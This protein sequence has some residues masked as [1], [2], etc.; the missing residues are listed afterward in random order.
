MKRFSQLF[1][2]LL[3]GVFLV[4]IAFEP[5]PV[6]NAQQNI[7]LNLEVQWPK[8]PSFDNSLNDIA[9][10]G[11]TLSTLVLFIYNFLLWLSVILAFVAIIY[12]GFLYIIS[13]ANPGERK[14]AKDYIQR[15]A[16]G[17]VILFLA[18][19]ILS[20]INTDL[21]EVDTSI[22]EA[23]CA[24][25]VHEEGCRQAL[26]GFVEQGL[27][28]F[29]LSGKGLDYYPIPVTGDGDIQSR[30]RVAHATIVEDKLQ[31]YL[32][33][34]STR[35][36]FACVPDNPCPGGDGDG[37]CSEYVEDCK[38]YDITR[39]GIW[40][41][42]DIDRWRNLPLYYIVDVLC[43]QIV[44][45]ETTNS[46]AFGDYKSGNDEECKWDRLHEI[47]EHDMKLTIER[48]DK[49]NSKNFELNA[50]NTELYYVVRGDDS[51][52]ASC[53]ARCLYNDFN[54]NAPDLVGDDRCPGDI[55]D[56]IQKLGSNSQLVAYQCEWGAGDTGLQ[57]DK[58]PIHF[59]SIKNAPKICKIG[60]GVSDNDLKDDDIGRRRA[61]CVAPYVVDVFDVPL[62][63]ECQKGTWLTS[64]GCSV[65][66]DADVQ[67]RG[68]NGGEERKL[69][70]CYCA[71]PP[72]K[73]EF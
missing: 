27:G 29:D 36:N 49:N 8:L 57:E 19:L 20:F 53:A 73:P 1:F 5:A 9:R 63:G 33:D 58:Q 46:Y 68:L 25:V 44:E 18:V 28:S 55:T 59:N 43:R 60:D 2:V 24:G 62:V 7:Q 61:K 30:L 54:G 14:K 64:T 13:G 67:H 66:D 65:G 15:I 37:R 23:Y 4:F 32:N 52:A 34:F 11:I 71:N 6:A 31:G 42:T 21:V 16:T 56:Y 51:G 35:N 3:V 69:S 48:A 38:Q 50:S 72:E 41:N 47:I 70:A 22:G 39:D 40:D 10:E 12:A 45:N 17:G 26:K